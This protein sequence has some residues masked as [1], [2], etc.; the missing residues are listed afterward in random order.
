MIQSI[1]FLGHWFVYETWIHFW[2]A[3]HGASSTIVPVIVALL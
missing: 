1:L 3:L 2:G